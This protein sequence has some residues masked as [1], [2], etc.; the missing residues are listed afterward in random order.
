MLLHAWDIERGKRRGYRIDGVGDARPTERVF[1][2]RY[3]IEL[4]RAFFSRAENSLG[5]KGNAT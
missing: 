3:E 4:T 2:P 1:S 5:S